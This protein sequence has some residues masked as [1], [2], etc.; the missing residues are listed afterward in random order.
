MTSRAALAVL[1]VAASLQAGCITFFQHETVPGPDPEAHVLRY[2]KEVHGNTLVLNNGYNV[3]L[4]ALAIDDL[5]EAQRGDLA[6]A[7]KDL[8]PNPGLAPDDKRPWQGLLVSPLTES[9]DVVV[10]V[11]YQPMRM[12]CGFGPINLFPIRDEVPPTRVDVNEYILLAGLAGANA[13]ADLE[14]S[15]RARYVAAEDY[16][17]RVGNGI[18]A[19]P[20]EQ[21][22]AAAAAGNE[23]EVRRLL[24]AGASAN[25]LRRAATDSEGTKSRYESLPWPLLGRVMPQQ[26]GT[27]TPLLAAASGEHL[28]VVKMLLAR[29]ADA[30]LAVRDEQRTWDP[31]VRPLHCAGWGNYSS[32]EDVSLEIYKAMVEA[33][34]EVRTADAE[35][36]LVRFE[37]FFNGWWKVIE[38]LT[39][40]GGNTREFDPQK[41]GP[42]L[43]VRAAEGNNADGIRHLLAYG[44][45]AG[46]LDSNGEYALNVAARQGQLEIAQTLLDA[47][48]DPNLK[49]RHGRAPLDSARKATNPDAMIELLRRRG[50]K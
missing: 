19:P 7:L 8:A 33:G 29:G 34:A 5:S 11:P 15:R 32:K 49:D 21:L 22:I 35:R 6:R 25:Y 26:R 27:V 9:G 42:F 31:P 44:A 3:T 24:D 18:W 16:A 20:G 39:A 2:V 38:Y 10:S 28:A 30:N 50:A 17:K 40:H 12:M 47:R 45:P 43:L 48:A 14:P 1:A 37:M 23:G 46:V 4:T 41:N 13:A 36:P